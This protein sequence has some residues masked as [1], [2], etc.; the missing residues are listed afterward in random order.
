MLYCK[1]CGVHIAGEARRC[2]LCQGELS[3]TPEEADCFPELP[4]R[5]AAFDLLLRLLALGS[6]AMTAI[7]VAVN[8]SFPGRGWWSAFVAAGL[9]SAWL[10]IG[11]A[12]WKRRR[13]LKAVFWLVCALSLLALA[14][15]YGTGGR[16]WAID[17]VLPILYTCTMVAMTAA[18][19]LL[20]L[21]PQDYLLYL[22][23][24][25]LFGI[26]P[27]ILLACGA[28]AVIYPS[29]IC[30]VVSVISLAALLLFERNAMWDELVRR[31]H[32]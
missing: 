18:A 12:V 1:K 2:P 26:I 29:V 19:R 4:V 16:G 31:L 28:L 25:V 13:P 11:I 17:F 20:H 23:L 32:L 15:D 6:V 3:G 22:S 8:F 27:V 9:A 14:W 7:C 21:R 30:A 24:S 10:T 5:T